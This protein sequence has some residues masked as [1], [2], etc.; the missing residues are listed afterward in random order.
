[1]M[2]VWEFGKGAWGWHELDFVPVLMRYEGKAREAQKIPL[3]DVT[4]KKGG[5]KWLD[6]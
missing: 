6:V 4:K 2:G 5:G 1:M 3:E